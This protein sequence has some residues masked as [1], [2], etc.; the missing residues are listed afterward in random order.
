MIDAAAAMEGVKAELAPLIDRPVETDPRN[1]GNLP[2]VLI[3]PPELAA[4]QSVLCGVVTYQFNLLV[5]GLPGAR[6]E[7]GPLSDLLGQV[8]EVVRWKTAVPVSYTP[9][10]QAQSADPCQAYLVTVDYDE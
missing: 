4:E 6:S 3:E 1:M 8:L 5:V 10:T 7:L 9:L 2:A